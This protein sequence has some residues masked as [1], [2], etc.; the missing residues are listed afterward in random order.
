MEGQVLGGVVQVLVGEVEDH[1]VDQV[2]HVPGRD[3]H[4]HVLVLL[5]DPE[6]D[7]QA[8]VG[9]EG[10]LEEDVLGRA[11]EGCR[12]AARRDRLAAQ[13]RLGRQDGAARPAFQDIEPLFQDRSDQFLPGIEP[14]AVEDEQHRLA[15]LCG[16]Q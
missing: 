11:D 1:D 5:L 2:R 16:S 8:E 14:E 15:P 9:L 4:R 3:P 12:Q 13:L 10:L 7:A 6:L